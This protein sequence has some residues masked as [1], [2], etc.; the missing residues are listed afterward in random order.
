MNSTHA[1]TTTRRLPPLNMLRAFEAAARCES[2]TLAAQEL[3]VTQSAV[4][5]QIKALE[6]WLGVP[7]V[8]RSGRG[9]GLTAEGAAYLPSLRSAFDLVAQ[10]TARI[11]Q[12]TRRNT[13]SVNSMASLS[14]QWL[15]PRL[16]AFCAEVPDVDVQ[17]ST[18]V[19]AFD[20]DPAA[21]DVSIR[22]MYDIERAEL[23]RKDK[24]QGVQMEAFLPESLTPLCSPQ[25]AHGTL[26]L[27]TPRDLGQHTLL[28]SRS[29]PLFWQDWLAA[30]GEPQLRP[31]NTLT[32]DHTHLAVQ[33]AIQGMGV[34]LGNPH[35]LRD[36]LDGGLLVR[37]FPE[38]EIDLKNVYWI[39]PPH[40]AQN[41]QALAFCRWLEE[42]GGLGGGEA[43]G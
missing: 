7:L 32:F 21:F 22:C 17:L 25:L 2:V 19:K 24:W 12:P 8:Q 27:Q 41:P 13:L 18:T 23:L 36:V 26:A 42:C 30:A 20:F 33:A 6:T 29:T 28:Q 9:L 31:A 35:Q 5:H 39:R 3:H 34:A 16:A 14:A 37:P 10:A 4:S 11:A 40:A 43:A 15:I 38:L 1:K